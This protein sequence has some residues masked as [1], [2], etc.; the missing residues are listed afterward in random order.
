MSENQER[1]DAPP[2]GQEQPKYRS[3]VAKGDL[4]LV[5]CT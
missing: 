5:S 2:A 3:F 1:R 4:K